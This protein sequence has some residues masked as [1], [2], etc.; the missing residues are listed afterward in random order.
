M[1]NLMN[2][3]LVDGDKLIKTRK[4]RINE[5]KLVKDKKNTEENGKS[6]QKDKDKNRMH[7]LVMKLGYGNRGSKSTMFREKFKKPSMRLYANSDVIE[8][9]EDFDDE[10]I[11]YD[12][13]SEDNT[14]PEVGPRVKRLRAKQNTSLKFFSN[15]IKSTD[16]KKKD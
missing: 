12:V 14:D 8:D 3:S 13:E 9:K 5:E 4:D 2:V 1:N 7:E 6:N 16:P 15:L 10:L 11:H